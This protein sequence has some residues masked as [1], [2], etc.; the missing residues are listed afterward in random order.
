MICV[1]RVVEGPATGMKCWLKQD[2]RITI[3]R[4]TTS[5]FSISADLHLSRTHMI[6][7]GSDV[8]FRI[9]DT[10]S[11]NGTYVN[12]SRVSIVELCGGDKIRAGK[13]V[14]SVEFEDENTSQEGR[15]RS[16]DPHLEE[17][18]APSLP[19][20]TLSSND[21][22][23]L[24]LIETTRLPSDAQLDEIRKD[25]GRASQDQT[26]KSDGKTTPPKTEPSKTELRIPVQVSEFF[27]VQVTKN[28]WT[29]SN[30]QGALEPKQIVDSLAQIVWS[31]QLALIVNRS[32]LEE[33]EGRALDFCLTAGEARRLT[34]TL[35]LIESENKVNLFEFYRRCL[36]KDAAICIAT[37]NKLT[38]HWIL[39]TIDL[40]SYP[41]MLFEVGS[42]SKERAYSLCSQ[43][44]F[45]LF[46]RNSQGDLCLLRC[47]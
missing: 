15:L 38:N 12:D 22:G 13:S 20:R 11:A 14:F 6:I 23:F 1:L 26:N 44:L 9:R 18:T 21:L 10:G 3:G 37:T 36:C 7:E 43:T 35:Y 24:D 41:S 30:G 31:A 28:L 29:Q 17:V 27:P 16:L 4:Q 34:D 45:L 32:Q 5:D 47:D 33:A 46:E 25:N 19:E 39:D 8:A 2:Q 40:L 42:R